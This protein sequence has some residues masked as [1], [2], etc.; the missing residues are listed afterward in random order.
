MNNEQIIISF[1]SYPKR[2][3]MVY[4]MVM[5]ILNNNKK[6]DLIICNL[7]EKEFIDKEKKLPKQLIDL[8]NCNKLKI[9]WEKDNLKA[10][11]KIKPTL[12][13]YPNDVIISVDDDVIYPTN[14]IEIIYNDYLKYNKKYPI[15]CGDWRDPN[16]YFNQYSHNG[17]YSLVKAEMFGNKLNEA[18]KLINE[19]SINELWADDILYTYA[20]IANNLEYKLSSW[21]GGAY[22][23]KQYM[24]NNYISGLS[25]ESLKNHMQ[26]H[27]FYKKFFNLNKY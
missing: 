26:Q 23:Y 7:S 17:S 4:D 25:D 13:K 27:I 9:N 1:T 19:N 6:P 2:I 14:F 3:N 8:I 12:D 15:T 10:Y 22:K 16:A 24:D 20:I 18:F 11:K 21:N 5:S